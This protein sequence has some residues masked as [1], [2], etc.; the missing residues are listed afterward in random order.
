[1]GSILKLDCEHVGRNPQI[2]WSGL[3]ELDS[4]TE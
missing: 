4:G 3:E 1:M 2:N